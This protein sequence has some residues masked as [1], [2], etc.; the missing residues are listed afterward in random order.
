[1]DAATAWVGTIYGLPSIGTSKNGV[2]YVGGRLFKGEKCY[3]PCRRAALSVG[4]QQGRA[5]SM[6]GL[7][8]GDGKMLPPP[9]FE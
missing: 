2:N 6:A 8:Y 4:A 9:Y 5:N 7:V 1:V 3:T